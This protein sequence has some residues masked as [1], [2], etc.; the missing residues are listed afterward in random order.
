MMKK[1]KEIIW[2][3]SVLFFI[4]LV[5]HIRVGIPALWLEDSVAINIKDTYFV[6]A[7]YHFLLLLAIV[8]I[9]IIYFIRILS[10]RL[11]NSIANS[12]FILFNLI[13]IS[14]FGHATLN[15]QDNQFDYVS[16]F[17]FMVLISFEI[18]VILKTMQYFKTN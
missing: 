11:K 10:G 8:T 12:I 5:F 9:F 17:I 7:P 16:L 4:A 13:P 6:I 14:F 18:F 15:F 1:Y 2:F 3:A